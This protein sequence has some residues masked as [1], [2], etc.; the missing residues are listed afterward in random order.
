MILE[1]VI[2]I[3]TSF[4]LILLLALRYVKRYEPENLIYISFST[5]MLITYIY[6]AI[7]SIYIPLK[8]QIVM[9]MLLVLI[10][11]FAVY[12]EY[13]NIILSR[14][15]LYFSM[16]FKFS[17]KE[18]EETIK[19]VNKLI[20]IEGRKAEYFYI[21]G[22]CYKYKRDYISS[23]DY[24]ALAIELDRRDYKSYYEL[25]LALYETNKKE[26]AIVMINN[27][28]RIKPDFYEASEALGICL[29]SMAKFEDAIKVYS[30]ALEYNPNSYVIYY[31][32]AMIYLELGYYEK[33]EKAFA[34]S[35]EIY[36]QLY[37]SC[38]NLGVLN[39]LNGN[40]DDAIIYLKM[41]T[42]SIVYNSKAYYKLAQV[43]MAKNDLNRSIA[44]LEY[45]MILKPEYIQK[46]KKDIAFEKI[47]DAISDYQK[48]TEK[49][50]N[51]KKYQKNKFIQK[52]KQNLF[53]LDDS[54]NKMKAN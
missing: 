6:C 29:T 11:T 47:Y 18:Y 10:P 5:I 40:Y 49:L 17:N 1:K 27:A 39:Y 51:E 12:L 43:Y 20:E 36:P 15:L 2:V 54:P 3:F 19:D 9:M 16:K 21:L 37:S 32:I 38:Y 13:S 4:V 31:N 28:L 50:E 23:R 25:G 35:I 53:I 24:F 46:A 42:G 41:S 48:Q 45:A 8:F 22:I 33:A 14:K 34:R 44:S 7:Y 26:T 30:N 52:I